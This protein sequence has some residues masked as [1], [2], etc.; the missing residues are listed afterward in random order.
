M[1]SS[2][3]RER[4]ASFSWRERFALLAA[5]L[6][7]MAVQLDWLA[8]NLSLTRIARDFSQPVTDLQWVL[9][10]YMLAFGGLLPFAG[11]LA[12]ARG[13]RRATIYGMVVFLVGSVVCA[14]AGD[15]VVLVVGRVVQ[16][17]GGA[18]VVPGAVAMISGMFR[19]RLKN[20]GLAFVLGAAGAGAALGPLVGG[21]FAELN[22]RYLFLVNVPVGLLAI[23]L[24]QWCVRPSYD[25]GATARRPPLT[26]T[27]SVV[28]GFVGF[29]LAVD[30]GSTWGWT[31]PTV[32][33]CALGGA[34]LLGN[35]ARQELRS[36]H[37]LYDRDFLLDPV[38]QLLTAVGALSLIAYTVVST[39]SAIYL[40]AT[41]GLPPSVAGGIVLA[42]SVSD[43]SASYAAGK[44]AGSAYA[45]VWLCAATA[46][47]GFGILLVVRAEGLVLYLT[48]LVVCGLGIGLAGAL[49]TVLT[50]HRTAPAK[51]AAAVSLS[52]AVKMLASA[53]ALAL[54]A[55]MAET[56][57]GGPS[58]AAV[59]VAALE[60]VLRATALLMGTG[61]LFLLPRAVRDLCHRGG[62]P[63]TG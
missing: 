5:A 4:P 49:T 8:V 47:I 29:T 18:L 15:L 23:P 11:W 6:S 59:D 12:D 62:G 10:A 36:S 39:F 27:C 20:R 63:G 9:T 50:Q 45:S 61:A 24:I 38:V 33:A 19:G 16:G 46:A 14:T 22:W 7:T 35:F 31:S 48:G 1:T 30:R 58:G 28:L 42:L 55:T 57:D 34:A 40:Q 26:S 32:L 17:V 13:R 2:A 52:L 51:A 53:V 41:Q 56:L 37:P 3:E 43:A 21:L 44:V 25:P 54:A 60:G